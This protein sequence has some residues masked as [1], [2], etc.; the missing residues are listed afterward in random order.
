MTRAMR[1]RSQTLF[2]AACVAGLV[3]LLFRSSGK[4][5]MTLDLVPMHGVAKVSKL[6][7]LDLPGASDAV[8][9]LPTDSTE[10]QDKL[11]VHLSTTLQCYPNHLVF[12]DYEETYRG[13]PLVDA[14]SSV[15]RQ[16]L[17][18]H[19]DFKLYRRLEQLGRSALLASELS[20]AESEAIQWHGKTENPGWKLD[21][22]KFLPMVNRTF[23]EFPNKKWYIFV[24]ANSFIFWRS[25]LQYLALIDH[26]KPHYSGSQMFIGDVLFAHGGSGFFVSQPA[27][28]MVVDYYALHQEEIEKFT[29]GAGP[30]I[31]Y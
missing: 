18:D 7:R 1:W 8:V 9:V 10:L 6:P 17:D 4:D 13:G 2:A 12:S 19:P 21:K 30:G 22:W 5:T 14:L 20:G 23:S 31:A 28:K 25:T 29:D 26:T 15:T 11:P 3:F 16:I 24:E 27:M